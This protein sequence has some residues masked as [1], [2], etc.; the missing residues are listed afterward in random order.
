MLGAIHSLRCPNA[1]S[2]HSA[3]GAR[4][5]A[6]KPSEN[7]NN[8]TKPR[9]LNPSFQLLDR[10]STSQNS[11]LSHQIYSRANAPVSFMVATG[12]TWPQST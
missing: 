1:W 10:G 9:D 7:T 6:S 12:H 11:G 3:R 4:V 5:V 8:L 2:Q